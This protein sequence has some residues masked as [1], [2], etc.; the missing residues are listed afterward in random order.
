MSLQF[1]SKRYF[2][3]PGS[4]ECSWLSQH[5]RNTPSHLIP[6]KSRRGIHP[7]RLTKYSLTLCGKRCRNIANDIILMHSG[8]HTY[9][10]LVYDMISVYFSLSSTQ[11]NELKQ[12]KCYERKS[13][14]IIT[15]PRLAWLSWLCNKRVISLWKDKIPSAQLIDRSDC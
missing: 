10:L 13:I 7:L 14:V 5:D 4:Q 1:V 11:T 15:I 3:A 8:T 9:S 6:T 12:Q 2:P